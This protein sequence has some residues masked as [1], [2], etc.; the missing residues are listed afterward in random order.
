MAPV[1]YHGSADGG[2]TSEFV[3]DLPTEYSYG[4]LPEEELAASP[5][6]SNTKQVEAEA[7]TVAEDSI[8]PDNTA[9]FLST[10]TVYQIAAVGL[11]AALLIGAIKYSGRLG[12][13]YKHLDEK[14]VV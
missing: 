11:I 5:P 3:D 7:T 1:A 8:V 12:R 2:A 9:S 6:T 14:S 13:G 4:R 10:D